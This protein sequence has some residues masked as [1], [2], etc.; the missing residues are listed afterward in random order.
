MSVL[1]DA[2]EWLKSFREAMPTD[3]GDLYAHAVHAAV[4]LTALESSQA[5]D[6]SAETDRLRSAMR[7]AMEALE[8]FAEQWIEY[9]S[10][11]N[12]PPADNYRIGPPIAL[13]RFRKAASAITTLKETCDE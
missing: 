10:K 3:D 6:Q 12:E 1:S 13:G 7:V 5:S 9:W 4:I 2:V 8:P 11:L